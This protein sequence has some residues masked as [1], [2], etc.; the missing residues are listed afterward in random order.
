LSAVSHRQAEPRQS[1]DDD[2][3]ESLPQTHLDIDERHQSHTLE[4]VERTKELQVCIV[5]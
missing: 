5:V 3:Y 2:L 1:E 4:Q